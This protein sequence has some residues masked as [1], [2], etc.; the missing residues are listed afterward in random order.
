MKPWTPKEDAAVLKWRKPL[1]G[2]VTKLGRGYSAIVRRAQK[3]GAKRRRRTH[4][5]PKEDKILAVEWGEVSLR[6]L[7]SKLPG[8]SSQAIRQRA[9]KMRL[10]AVPQGWVSRNAAAKRLGID[11]SQL[12]A[13]LRRHNL[14]AR[15]WYACSSAQHPTKFVQLDAVIEAFSSELREFERVSAIA[16]RHGLDHDTL[17]RW[18]KQD[19][20]EMLHTERTSPY[21]VRSQE[22]VRVMSSRGWAR[23]RR[24]VETAARELGISVRVLWGALERSGLL[25]EVSGPKRPRFVSL[26]TARR[27][28]GMRVFAGPCRVGARAVQRRA[29]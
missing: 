17:L 26:P 21:L 13:L 18:L 19:G 23:G 7:R 12:D 5:T 22:A 3:I 4:W 29:A 16:R 15:R 1:A 6:E 24:P 9:T 14:K 2:L 10:G 11:V 27:A 20:A 25:P 8:R 28:L